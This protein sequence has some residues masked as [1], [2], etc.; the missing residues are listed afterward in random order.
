MTTLGTDKTAFL[1]AQT[2]KYLDRR[3]LPPLLSYILVDP[4]PRFRRLLI[5]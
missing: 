3:L 4:L 5:K 2:R 1:P